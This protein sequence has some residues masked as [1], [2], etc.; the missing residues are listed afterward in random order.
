MRVPHPIERMEDE[1]RNEV[2]E[3]NIISFNVSEPVDVI[4][5]SGDVS[6]TVSMIVNDISATD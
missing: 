4:V 3:V 5:Q 1:W 2:D 6:E